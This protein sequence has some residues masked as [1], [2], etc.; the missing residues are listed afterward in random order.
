M[1]TERHLEMKY[2]LVLLLSLL[3]N[4]QAVEVENN[5]GLEMMFIYKFSQNMSLETVTIK[6]G[7]TVTFL[8]ETQLGTGYDWELEKPIFDVAELIED[9]IVSSNSLIIGGSGG[10]L[11]KFRTLKKGNGVLTFRYKRSWEKNIAPFKILKINFKV[12]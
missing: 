10:H 8:L 5:K 4:L 9:S 7:K 1:R 12:D 3:F 11:F 2:V 6:E